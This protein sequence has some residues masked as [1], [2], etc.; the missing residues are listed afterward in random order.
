L[1]RHRVS[2]PHVVLAA[3]AAVAIVSPA[4]AALRPA[5]V[6]GFFVAPDEP[7]R[8]RWRGEPAGPVGYTIR[9]YWGK[10]VAAGRAKAAADGTVEVTVKLHQGFYDIELAAAK[11]RFGVVALPALRGEADPFF[12]IDAAMSWLVTADDV[13]EGLVRVLRR[14]GIGMSRERLS[15]GQISPAA[16]RWDFQTPRR[17]ERLRKAHARHGVEVLEMFHD[18]PG[19]LGHVGKYPADLPAATRAW[20]TIIGRLRGTWGALEVWNEPD[21]F[22]GANLP[23]DQYVPLVRA[24]AWALARSRGDTP[25]VGGVFAHH[26]RRYLDSAADNGMLACLDAASFHTY[27]RAPPV[28]RQ[29][30]V[31][32]PMQG[33]RRLRPSHHRHGPRHAQS[34]ECAPEGQSRPTCGTSRLFFEHLEGIPRPLPRFVSVRIGGR[35]SQLVPVGDPYAPA[36]AASEDLNIGA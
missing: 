13:R 25:L 28:E 11:Q 34:V 20:E 22:F 8:L 17:Y 12:C 24:V 33:H 9:D 23:A 36:L 15:W 27:G 35:G 3:A 30:F 10:A 7:A 4:A 2:G 1:H 32:F 16:G 18:A 21:I 5:N 6:E 31:A 26:N 19:H 14:S 29:T